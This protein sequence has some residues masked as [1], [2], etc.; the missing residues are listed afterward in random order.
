[1]ATST[2]WGGFRPDPYNP[3]AV[4]GDN[5]G[6][7]QEGTLFERPAGTRFIN[8]DGT[9]LRD[10]LRGDNLTVL[11]GIRL[12]DEDGKPVEYRQSWR[13]G[14]I[15]LGQSIGTIDSLGLQTIGQRMGEAE[16]RPAPAKAA[17]KPNMN[18]ITVPD[19]YGGSRGLSE[20]RADFPE[21]FDAD[22]QL[23][24]PSRPIF[25]QHGFQG[26]ANDL[27]EGATSWSDVKERLRGKTIIAYDYETTDFV[28]NGG[29]AVQIGAVKMVDG[30]VVD[31]INIYMNP[32]IPMEEWSGFSRDNLKYS[33]GT[34]LSPERVA[35]FPSSR[36]A[37]K[38][39][40][41]WIG[42]DEEFYMMGHNALAFDDILLEREYDLA[43]IDRPKP[44]GRI[45]TL[46]L[47]R[48]INADSSISQRNT[49]TALTDALGI[50]LGEKAHTADA[51]S[52]ATA[53][54][55]F[56]LLDHAEEKDLPVDLVAPDS[57]MRR[58]EERRT[59]FDTDM[60]R[61]REASKIYKE[62]SDATAKKQSAQRAAGT[63]ERPRVAPTEASLEEQPERF[64]ANKNRETLSSA[65]EYISSS[66]TNDP[67]ELY[68]DDAILYDVEDTGYNGEIKVQIRLRED[69]TIAGPSERAQEALRQIQ[70]VG[71]SI[72][73]EATRRYRADK[74]VRELEKRLEA[75]Q[76]R[77][78]ELQTKY[79][80]AL[81]QFYEY[82]NQKS[83]EMFERRWIELDEGQREQIMNS[84]GSDRDSERL[85]DAQI[86]AEDE[87]RRFETNFMMPIIYELR[88]KQSKYISDVLN[89]RN[90]SGDAD[91]EFTL[92]QATPD[93]VPAIDILEVTQS[94]SLPDI[95]DENLDLIE[96]TFEEVWEMFPP[97]L[98]LKLQEA[99]GDS[100]LSIKI[101][102]I[103]NALGYFTT[104]EADAPGLYTIKIPPSALEPQEGKA[105]V[106]DYLKQLL[107][108]EMTHALEEAHPEMVQASQIFIAQRLSGE[109]TADFTLSSSGSPSH[110]DEFL[111]F[112]TGAL[113]DTGDGEMFPEA[114]STALEVLLSPT[115]DDG[116]DTIDDDHVDFLLGALLMSDVS[117]PTEGG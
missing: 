107:S 76:T 111:N 7:V 45:D 90:T 25:Y 108:H 58:E 110:P 88:L 87:V 86:A 18:D 15:S 52:E 19:K 17:A 27:M 78:L 101:G 96:Q 6:I 100:G 92:A 97:S 82:R 67:D 34:L 42:A 99:V 40:M 44:A 84:L 93:I 35:S 102:E 33:D 23:K 72:R 41:D 103:E 94:A 28:D 8:L 56:K 49:L 109:S 73:S 4:D 71:R 112:Y 66:L 11:N 50:E 21:L 13:S 10:M 104:E 9:E 26:G 12:V 81:E 48:D 3:N 116:I 14:Q 89:G 63:D 2:R 113:Y 29:R 106:K 70:E 65:L 30:E 20:L 77:R 37:H 69:G 53:S 91:P 114:L 105:S 62:I 43:D 31:R 1:M 95:S 79:T 51:D 24:K 68:E 36:D 39:F 115:L 5:D 60:A 83:V 61:Y 47:S 117:V 59:K 85:L 98:R 57:A 80:D 16:P 46:S 38:Q 74:E 32:G 75:E 22:G 54:L 55:L 64:D